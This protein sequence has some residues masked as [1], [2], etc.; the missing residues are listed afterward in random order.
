LAISL[1]IYYPLVRILARSSGR[2]LGP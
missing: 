2:I 1:L